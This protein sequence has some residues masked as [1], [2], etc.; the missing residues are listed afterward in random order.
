MTPGTGT[1]SVSS[2]SVWFQRGFFRS[3]VCNLGKS[4]TLKN[5]W[6]GW[7]DGTENAFNGFNLFFVHSKHWGKIH[8]LKKPPVT[9]LRGPPKTSSYEVFSPLAM[10]D[11]VKNP[12][13]VAKTWDSFFIL[14][15]QNFSANQLEVRGSISMISLRDFWSQSQKLLAFFSPAD[16]K[17][18]CRAFIVALPTKR[19][20]LYG[21]LE[22][23]PLHTCWWS[24]TWRIIPGLVST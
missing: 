24:P 23:G 11:D 2:F 9:G 20:E 8:R 10:F 18:R 13:R 12:G 1:G 6:K 17:S 14:M 16:T 3:W 19:R 22:G 5:D 21:Y 15:L 4:E 7:E